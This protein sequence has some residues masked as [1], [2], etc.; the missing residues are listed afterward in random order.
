MIY[1]SFLLIVFG[2]LV[3]TVSLLAVIY[4]LVNT[5]GWQRGDDVA[6]RWIKIGLSGLGMILLGQ[7]IAA[8]LF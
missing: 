1:L 5:G 8:R 4:R 3:F 2:L 7:I 6:R